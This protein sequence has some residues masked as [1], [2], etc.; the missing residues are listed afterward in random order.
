MTLPVNIHSMVTI[1]TSS[2]AGMDMAVSMTAISPEIWSIT[3]VP[4]GA[5]GTGSIPLCLKKTLE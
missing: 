4:L 1:T 2:E 3:M 5:T